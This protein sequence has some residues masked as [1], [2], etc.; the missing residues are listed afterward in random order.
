MNKPEVNLS[1]LKLKNKI[2]IKSKQVKKK[3][4]GLERWLAV[5]G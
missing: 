5:K 1:D 2:A 3:C 4:T